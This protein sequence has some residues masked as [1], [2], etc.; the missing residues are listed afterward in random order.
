MS[1]E[2]SNPLQSGADWLRARIGCLTASRAHDVVKR[3]RNGKPLAAYDELKRTLAAERI[4]NT[5]LTPAA[6]GA[7][8]QWGQDNE[9]AARGEYELATGESVDLVGFVRHPS[10]PYFGA[11][12][13]GLIC[14]EGL[15]EIKCPYNCMR[16]VERVADDAIPPEYQTQMCVQLLCTGREFCD[17]VSFDPRAPEGSKLR[18][19][20]KRFYPTPEQLTDVR[21][22]CTEFLA[23]VAAEE[24]RLRDI[25]GV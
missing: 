12:P 15:V 19:W 17:F 3:G 10:I 8:I 22:K 20:I 4:Y 1:L 23:L 11:S 14:G 6:S 24:A 16:Q 18:L 7:A 5:V 2:T 13:D 25:F 9:E 21:D